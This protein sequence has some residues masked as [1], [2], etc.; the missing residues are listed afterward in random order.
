MTF[1]GG[2][3]IAFAFAFAFVFGVPLLLLRAQFV[4]WLT[5]TNAKPIRWALMSVI[6]LPSV[7]S[8]YLD[9]AAPIRQS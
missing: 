6:L 4:G 9:N 5:G 7:A 1:E 8:I 2:F 3:L